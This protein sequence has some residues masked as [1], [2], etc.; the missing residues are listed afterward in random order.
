MI[1]A[2]MYDVPYLL[3]TLLMFLVFDLTLL[4][5]IDGWR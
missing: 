3:M 1:S 2:F 4:I 5:I